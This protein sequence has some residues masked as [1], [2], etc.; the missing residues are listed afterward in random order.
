MGDDH[1]ILTLSAEF[2]V[3]TVVGGSGTYAQ[4]RVILL[5]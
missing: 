1:V 4:S 2:A 3:V 5:E